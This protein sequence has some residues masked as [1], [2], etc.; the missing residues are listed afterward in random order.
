MTEQV[1]SAYQIL[2]VQSLSATRRTTQVK[3]AIIIF[4]KTA[5]ERE[6]LQSLK[7]DQSIN[8]TK[9]RIQHL[10]KHEMSSLDNLFSLN[11][12]RKLLALLEKFSK[13]LQSVT[14]SADYGC[15]SLR[16]NIQRL[17][18]M[19]CMEQFNV[20]LEE[21]KKILKVY[22]KSDEVRPRKDP[23]RMED[24]SSILKEWL[25]ATP[26]KITIYGLGIRN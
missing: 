14:I 1:T 24:G 25:P 10:L 6:T 15:Y 7:T 16:Y 11:A 9:A 3:A 2:R 4:E 8:D 26:K 5:E 12:T 22:G 20:L 17:Q 19:R 13:E 18:Q 21:S 23:R